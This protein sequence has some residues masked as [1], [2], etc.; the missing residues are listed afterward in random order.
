MRVLV[1][2]GRT[3]S[4]ADVINAALNW[5]KTAYPD[6]LH[7]CQGGQTGADRIAY[8]W[9]MT[10]E[11]PCT[12][13]PAQWTRF[14]KPAGPMRNAQMLHRFRPHL[15][16]YAQGGRGTGDM[17]Q[18][19]EAAGITVVA[20]PVAMRDLLAAAEAAISARKLL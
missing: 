16:L 7:V 6:S 5:L 3:F 13:F 8:A 14:G 20:L 1:C 18:K 10:Q 12:T 4:E 15:V 9:A 17:R 19:A 2:G 11:I